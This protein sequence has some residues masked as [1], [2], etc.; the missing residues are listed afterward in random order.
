MAETLTYDAGTDT[1][2]SSENLTP[3]EQD[4]LRV[5]EEMA[6][7]QEQLLAGKYANAQEL[8]KAYV[9]LEKKL[10]TPQESQPEATTEP[11]PDTEPEKSEEKIDTAFLD[12][13]WDEA[14]GEDFKEETLKE[15]SNM[16]ANTIAK[17]YLEERN[18]RTEPEVKPITKE[19]EEKLKGIVGGPD[20]YN[21][22]MGWAKQN[23]DPEEIKMYDTV[24]NQGNALSAFFAVQALFSRYSDSQG[25]D[26]P[27][28]TGKPPTSTPKDEF[29]SQAELVRAM[30]DERY[31]H[32]PAYRQDIMRK[33]ERSNVNF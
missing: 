15:L 12:R 24:M 14:Q 4:S 3:D 32:D 17:M 10:G 2:S 28:I 13:L 19:E 18:N 11:E 20:E 7:Q 21:S 27:L 23:L 29:R 22:M 26:K 31:D 30:S 5:G 1:V 16:D 8:E 6:Q 25:T 9:E 33:L